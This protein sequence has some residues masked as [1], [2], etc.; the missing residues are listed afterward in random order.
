MFSIMDISSR[1]EN[2]HSNRKIAEK[3]LAVDLLTE[4]AG[5]VTM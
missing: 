5:L 2:K 3:K 1:Q 4:V